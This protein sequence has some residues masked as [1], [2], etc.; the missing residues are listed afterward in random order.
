RKREY[1]TVHELT[2]TIPEGTFV[3]EIRS[4]DVGVMEDSEPHG[5]VTLEGNK[6]RVPFGE[7]RVGVVQER[8]DLPLTPAEVKRLT[9]DDST[10]KKSCQVFGRFLTAYSSPEANK[11]GLAAPLVGRC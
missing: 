10:W 6:L 4:S 11:A 2:L 7:P 1:R 9:R 8:V 3:G 5:M